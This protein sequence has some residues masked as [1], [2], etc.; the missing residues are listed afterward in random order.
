MVVFEDAEAEA[1][2]AVDPLE[3]FAAAVDTA[4]AMFFEDFAAEAEE[5]LFVDP[6]AARIE[7]R[8]DAED[9]K[10]A[11]SASV[12]LADVPDTATTDEVA[13]SGADVA[14]VADAVAPTDQTTV[15]AAAEAAV[16]SKP[17]RMD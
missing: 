5:T 9:A 11:E 14:D 1:E 17:D 8:L 7:G 15:S 12:L 6:A 13:E 2:A 16:E 3:I 10:T 4:E